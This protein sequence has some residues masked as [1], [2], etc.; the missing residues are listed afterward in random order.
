MDRR[1]DRSD[2]PAAVR[3][4]IN[5]SFGGAP[6]S[7]A[8]ASL[9]TRL[10]PQT[11]VTVSQQLHAEGLLRASRF[12]EERQPLTG[13]AEASPVFSIGSGNGHASGTPSTT[14]SPNKM[15][16][17]GVGIAG[18]ARFGGNRALVIAQET[19][20]LQGG[21]P[22]RLVSQ[23]AP[24]PAVGGKIT[25][26]ASTASCEEH[27]ASME[28]SVKTFS[29]T[30]KDFQPKRDDSK[31]MQVMRR[32]EEL[33][34]ELEEQ[35]Q[36]RRVLEEKAQHLNKLLRHERGER[37]AWLVAFLTSL[38]TTLQE[39]TG[40]IDRSISDSSQLMKNSM[41]GTDEVMNHL[42]DRVDQL[43][44]QK[45]SEL[46]PDQAELEALPRMS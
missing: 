41:D 43:L 2:L 46:T 40:C 35:R 18:G 17:P 6:G 9:G 37:E 16:A 23:D 4:G 10:R 3:L 44:I 31:A 33:A 19:S 27:I 21:Y 20:L 39:L 5:Q 22:S 34:T 12:I 25:A 15:V 36:S 45:E 13:A 29:H 1:V 26:L 24:S 28:S 38:H 32:C 14:S 30:L 11:P 8:S 7:N 42:I